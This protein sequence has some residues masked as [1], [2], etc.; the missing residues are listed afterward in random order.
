MTPYMT[1]PLLGRK[2]AILISMATPDHPERCVMP[3]I[4]AAVAAAMECEV[5]VHFTSSSVRLLVTGVAAGLCVGEGDGKAVYEHMQEAARQ[6]V[7]FIG[8]SMALKQYLA[9]DELKIPEFSGAAG[10][11]TLVMRSLDPE[12][13]V[14][15]F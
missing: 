4:Y 8:C 12:W 14:L 6:G 9:P 15:C 10:A 11:A 5:E 7:R 3:F 1:E 2:L 13:R